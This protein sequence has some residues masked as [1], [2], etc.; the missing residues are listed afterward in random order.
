MRV[1]SQAVPSAEYVDTGLAA[2]HTYYYV[3]AAVDADRVETEY[4]VPI[5]ATVPGV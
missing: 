5:S 1:S 2:G 3:V 4:S